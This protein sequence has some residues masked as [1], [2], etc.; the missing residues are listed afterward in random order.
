MDRLLGGREE[1]QPA[2]VLHPVREQ[3]RVRLRRDVIG[4]EQVG[5]RIMH[6]IV[7]RAC[8]ISLA[9]FRTVSLT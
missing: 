2:A 9:P 5:D 6:I 3:L 1:R 4:V 8:H 7:V